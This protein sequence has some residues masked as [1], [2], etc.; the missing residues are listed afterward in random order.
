MVRAEIQSKW[1]GL[2]D[3]PVKP[4]DDNLEIVVRSWFTSKAATRRP[5]LRAST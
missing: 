4:G 3:R 2:L 1:P 5:H